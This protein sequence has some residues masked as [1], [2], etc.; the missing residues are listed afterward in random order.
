[1]AVRGGE[2]SASCPSCFTVIEKA[3]V[4]I[5]NQAGCA[6]GLI[7]TLLLKEKS[8]APVRIQTPDHLACYPVT[9]TILLSWFLNSFESAAIQ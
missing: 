1:V 3:P 5:G 8:L 2:W 4:P 7:W 6:P 9:I